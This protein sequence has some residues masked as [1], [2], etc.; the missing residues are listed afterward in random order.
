MGLFVILEKGDSSN[1][2]GAGTG[3]FY[4]ILLLADVEIGAEVMQKRPK[5]DGVYNAD[6]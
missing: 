6:P 4:E 1:F 5:V 3:R 2:F